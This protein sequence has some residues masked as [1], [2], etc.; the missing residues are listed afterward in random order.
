MSVYQKLK[1]LEDSPRNLE[2]QYLHAADVLGVEYCNV[3][4][5]K[6]TIEGN[7][8]V[9]QHLWAANIVSDAGDVYY[10]QK[11]AGETPTNDFAGANN[12]LVLRTGTVATPLKTHTYT[13]VTSPVSGS[14][15]TVSNTY[16]KTNDGD[17]L[18]NVTNKTRKVTWKYDYLTSEAN[19]TG[20]LGG[21]IHIGGNSPVGGTLLL[22]HFNFAASFDKTS[23]DT[24]TVYVNHEMLG[25]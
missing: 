23:N 7:Y 16:P 6:D 11:A 2:E 1:L 17:A 8:L 4:G 12:R 14:G 25:S 24:L 22:T 5:I 21:A 9:R 15:K 3:H 20:I 13:N 19:T 10:A 18:N